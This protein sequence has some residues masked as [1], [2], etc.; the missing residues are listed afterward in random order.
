MEQITHR[1]ILLGTA[2]IF[3]THYVKPDQIRRYPH[4]V[5]LPSPGRQGQPSPDPR[6]KWLYEQ[7]EGSR[8]ITLDIERCIDGSRDY[9]REYRFQSEQELLVFKLRWQGA[10]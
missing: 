7:W 10:E 4:A 6:K 9:W 2:P 3:R 5:A 8:W 1:Y